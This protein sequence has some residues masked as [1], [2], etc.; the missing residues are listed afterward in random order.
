MQGPGSVR[1]PRVPPRHLPTER[2]S[3]VATGAG[4]VYEELWEEVS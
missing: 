1:A 4:G 2:P 3:F